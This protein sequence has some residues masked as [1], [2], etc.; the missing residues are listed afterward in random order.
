MSLQP[1]PILHVTDVKAGCD[2]FASVLLRRSFRRFP[3]E[4]QTQRGA[5]RIIPGLG[6]V[7]NNHGDRFRPLRIGQRGTPSK[8]PFYG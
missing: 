4:Q 7:A 5:W 3:V 1:V 8:W 6:Y 2:E